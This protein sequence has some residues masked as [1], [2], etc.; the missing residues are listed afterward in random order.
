MRRGF[1]QH[2]E[3]QQ[4]F[5]AEIPELGIYAQGRTRDDLLY[6]IASQIA[7]LWDE[8]AVAKESELSED[9]IELHR[10]LLGRLKRR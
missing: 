9:A 5:V 8:Y 1:A 10:V 6:D 4:H 7:F 3:G 2:E